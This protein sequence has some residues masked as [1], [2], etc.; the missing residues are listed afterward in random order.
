MFLIAIDGFNILKFKMWLKFF[1][2]NQGKSIFQ[3]RYLSILPYVI[4]LKAGCIF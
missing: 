1:K 2:V 3:I 4:E